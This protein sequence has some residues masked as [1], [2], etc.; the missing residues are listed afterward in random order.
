M[1]YYDV[2]ILTMQYLQA[3]SMSVADAVRLDGEVLQQP[4]TPVVKETN[5]KKKAT[6]KRA[7]ME[8]PM[9]EKTSFVF[10]RKC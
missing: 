9:S 6:M 8:R 7:I 2:I 1:A 3:K 4:T 10:L 5:I